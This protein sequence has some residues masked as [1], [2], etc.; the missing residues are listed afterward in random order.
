MTTEPTSVYEALNPYAMEVSLTEIIFFK[1]SPFAFMMVSILEKMN[2]NESLMK[3]EA[4]KYTGSGGFFTNGRLSVCFSKIARPES[5][6]VYLLPS[7][8]MPVER[9]K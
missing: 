7:K 2:L 9:A 4:H 5:H 6:V 3:S 1:W 8:G